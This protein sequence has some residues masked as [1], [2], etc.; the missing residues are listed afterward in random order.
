[1]HI[2]QYRQFCG[3][4]EFVFIGLGSLFSVGSAYK[5]S[6]SFAIAFVF[7]SLH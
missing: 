1:M 6:Q 3:D 7:S 4:Q 2:E 5:P